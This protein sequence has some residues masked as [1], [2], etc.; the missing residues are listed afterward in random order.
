MKIEKD[1][2]RRIGKSLANFPRTL[3]ISHS[4][5]AQET[6]KDPYNFDFLGLEDDAQERAIETA[7]TDRITDFLLELGKGFAFIGRQYKLVGQ[8]RVTFAFGTCP[9]PIK[10]GLEYFIYCCTSV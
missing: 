4:G 7:L 10:S 9:A 1:K 8:S 5:L 6:I 2:Y 3:P